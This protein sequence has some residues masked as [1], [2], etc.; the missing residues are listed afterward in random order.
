MQY[1]TTANTI[2]NFLRNYGELN[3]AFVQVTTR[4]NALCTDRR[5]IWASTPFH[6]LLCDAKSVID[7]LAKGRFSVAFLEGGETGLYPNLVETVNYTK[8]KGMMTSL[9]RN[10]SVLNKS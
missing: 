5:D 10:G 3:F 8:D 9:T 4:C 1:R 7:V 2:S 6:L